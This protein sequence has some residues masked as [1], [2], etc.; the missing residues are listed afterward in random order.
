MLLSL[1]FLS[2]SLSIDSLGIGITYG[3][4]NTK[5]SFIPKCILF[6]ISLLIAYLSIKIGNI[7]N[8]FL[9][10]NIAKAFGSILLCLMGIWI[11]YQSFRSLTVNF[12]QLSILA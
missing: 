3:L 10:D 4:K 5:I 12:F 6:C 1:I 9:P 11:I 7:L 2:I 8:Y